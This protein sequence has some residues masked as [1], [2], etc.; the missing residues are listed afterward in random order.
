V[1]EKTMKTAYDL[2]H[3]S[4]DGA[5]SCDPDVPRFATLAEAM[6]AAGH[7]DAADW[8][9]TPSGAHALH[10]D[11]AALAGY[12]KGQPWIISEERVAET[13]AE[14]VEL[15]L[16]VAVEFGQTDGDHHKAWVIDQM[17]RILTGD[18]YGQWVAEYRDGGEYAWDEG[19]AP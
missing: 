1:K 5:V 11:L 15:A 13:D 16:D 14:R 8:H 18:R 3:W 2:Y 19:I 6:T 17:V 7:P 9:V 4:T 12:T 10:D